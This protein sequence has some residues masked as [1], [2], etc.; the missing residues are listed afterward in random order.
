MPPYGSP[1]PASALSPRPSSGGQVHAG[2][3]HYSQ[4]NSMGNYGPQGGQYVPQGNACA[5]C[6]FFVI[7]VAKSTTWYIV[8]K[9]K[10]ALENHKTLIT[11]FICWCRNGTE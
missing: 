8:L 4:S 3:G 10:K 7:R 6:D 11:E 5:L 1:Q 2:M 9:K